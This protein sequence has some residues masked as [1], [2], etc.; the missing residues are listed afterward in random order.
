MARVKALY[1]YKGQGMGFEKGEVRHLELISSKYVAR[2]FGGNRISE[3][4]GKFL[5][6]KLPKKPSS[7]FPAIQYLFY[8][9]MSI[10]DV[11]IEDLHQ[12]T[13]YIHTYVTSVY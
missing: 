7:K 2:Y 13:F 8:I 10:H 1:R 12:L 6:A 3:C 9:L 11:V 4:I 5:K